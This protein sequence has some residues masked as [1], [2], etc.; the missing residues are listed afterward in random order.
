MRAP[1]IVDGTINGDRSAQGGS[2]EE[3][4]ANIATLH[5]LIRD[6]EAIMLEQV[7]AHRRISTTL[8]VSAD[9]LGDFFG[10]YVIFFMLGSDQETIDLLVSKPKLRYQAVPEWAEIRSFVNGLVKKLSSGDTG[11]RDKA[12]PTSLGQGCTHL[13]LV[14]NESPT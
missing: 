6:D 12:S 11:F 13:R 8:L 2:L 14:T 4:V 10:K 9:Q 1:S 7:V 3:A 5:Q